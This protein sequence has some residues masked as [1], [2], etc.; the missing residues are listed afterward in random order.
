MIVAVEDRFR[1]IYMGIIEPDQHPIYASSTPVSVVLTDAVE[2]VMADTRVGDV[3][4]AT[5]ASVAD[6]DI[7]LARSCGL[8]SAGLVDPTCLPAK[9]GI[10]DIVRWQDIDP[11]SMLGHNYMDLVRRYKTSGE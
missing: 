4:P 10:V 5:A 9:L 6:N 8:Y 11:D 7:P 2:V 3:G 1:R